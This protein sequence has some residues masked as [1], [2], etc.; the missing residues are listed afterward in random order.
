MKTTQKHHTHGFT[1]SKQVDWQ[2]LLENLF[3]PYKHYWQNAFATC[4]FFFILDII[5]SK[6]NN[7]WQKAEIDFLVPV[8]YLDMEYKQ[9]KSSFCERNEIF[10]DKEYFY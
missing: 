9:K 3:I 6:G 4:K 10:V 8:H 1:Y 7:R 5:H 2:T